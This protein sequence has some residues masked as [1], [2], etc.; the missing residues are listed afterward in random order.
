MCGEIPV[1]KRDVPPPR[2][3]A[4]A[5]PGCRPSV[6]LESGE[7]YI[8]YSLLFLH[9]AGRSLGAYSGKRG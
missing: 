3:S 5:S 2:E 4:F 9:K 6:V 8:R 7:T 1:E